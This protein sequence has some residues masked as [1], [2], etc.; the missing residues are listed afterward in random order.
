MVMTESAA[1]V[2]AA[3][4]LNQLQCSPTTILSDNQQLVHFLNGSNLSNPPDW[5]INQYT[6]VTTNLLTGSNLAVRKIKRNQNRMAD[7]LARQALYALQSNQLQ[8]SNTCTNP[9]QD[10]DCPV[11]RAINAV[12]I[13]SV[14]VLSTSCC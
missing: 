14:M 12:T 5:R 6:Q 1:L 11:L 9:S 4:L 8:H 7:S 10:N 13:N 3:S 2:F